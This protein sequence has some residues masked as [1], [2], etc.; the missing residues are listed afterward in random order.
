MNGPPKRSSV[1]VCGLEFCV[2]L[3][4]E[5]AKF[6]C[7]FVLRSEVH[8][9]QYILAAVKSRNEHTS[10]SSFDM[11]LAIGGENGVVCRNARMDER[12]EKH[13][14]GRVGEVTNDECYFLAWR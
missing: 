12:T 10:D 4:K 7:I 8:G 14:E 2:S 11:P 5:E 1:L 3:G 13:L 6:Q 9:I